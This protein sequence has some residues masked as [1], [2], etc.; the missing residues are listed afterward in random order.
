MRSIRQKQ[1]ICYVVLLW[2]SLSSPP[3]SWEE[4]GGG[5]SLKSAA[6][7]RELQGWSYVSDPFSAG[8]VLSVPLHLGFFKEPAMVPLQ[9][10]HLLRLSGPKG[11]HALPPLVSLFPPAAL[12]SEDTN[13][14]SPVSLYVTVYTL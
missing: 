5:G 11:A 1:G 8:N 13:C 10:L 6:N 9:H 7:R 4:S 14:H 3:H 2:P 12:L